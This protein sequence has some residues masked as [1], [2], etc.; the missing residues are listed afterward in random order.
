[1]TKTQ[2]PLL[3]IDPGPTRS[4][5]CF[6]EETSWQAN[7]N[8]A[9]GPQPRIP[10]KFTT[11][12]MVNGLIVQSLIVPNM[13]SDF[14]NADLIIEG[15]VSY[16][17]PIGRDVLDTAVW[18]GR[19]ETY[20]ITAVPD[21][22]IRPYIEQI[23]RPAVKLELCN[24]RT[25]KDTNVRQAIIDIYGGDEKA[26]RGVKCPECRG[27]GWRGRGRPP[28]DAC[29]DPQRPGEHGTGYLVPPGPLVGV[30]S[31]GWSA[32]ALAVT[33]YRIASRDW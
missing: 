5:F 8:P 28:C 24:N 29:A 9:D 19:F 12:T 11:G 18:I 14:D 32:L 26:L 13:Q 25:A 2:K 31:H 6:V 1:M 16:G 22:R 15:M 23:T 27:Q 3:A 17:M 20:A 10:S 33:F 30:A 21:R 7:W 4:G